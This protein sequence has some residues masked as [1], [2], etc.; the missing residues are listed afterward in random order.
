MATPRP[1]PVDQLK[2]LTTDQ[3]G[4]LLIKLI[5]DVDHSVSKHH[6]ATIRTRRGSHN[7]IVFD[8]SDVG[9]ADSTLINVLVDAHRS[10]I[11]PDQHVV[12]LDPPA[13]MVRLLDMTNV[14]EMCTFRYSATTGS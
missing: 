8:M 2:I 12:V 7:E 3:G 9:F 13:M 4:R 10:L 14:D 6:L 11:G 5:G 1:T